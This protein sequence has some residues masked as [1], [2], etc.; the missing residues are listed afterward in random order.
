MQPVPPLRD[1]DG[2]PVLLGT[3]AVRVVTLAPSLTE[4]V[5]AAGA[6]DKLAGVSAYSD[7][8]ANATRLPVMSDAAGISWEGLLALNP[9]LV[10]A[11]KG[12]TRDA[13]IS[14]LNAL[15]INVFTIEIKRLDDVAR[16]L[17]AIGKLVGRPDPAEQAARTYRHQLE[18]LREANA[19]K[20]KIGVFFEISGKPLMTINRDHVITEAMTVCGGRNV[21]ADAPTLVIEP[22]REELLKRKPDAILHGKT[23]KGDRDESQYKGLS[24]ATER[25][26]GI[27]ADFV[28]RPGPRLLLATQEICAALDRSRASLGAANP[29]QR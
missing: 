8:P 11:W 10:L 5:F 29:R 21:F 6:G 16:A 4:L 15:G 19:G 1:D 2:R 22:S 23:S 20:Q 9:D 3:P 28:F 7:Y 18:V 17:R 25:N 13:D 24:A 27:T 14:R 26:Y 12:G